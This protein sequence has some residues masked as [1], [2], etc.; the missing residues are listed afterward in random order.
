MNAPDERSVLT[1]EK[2]CLGGRCK[3]NEKE[4]R[5]DGNKRMIMKKK[6][7]E[8]WCRIDTLAVAQLIDKSHLKVQPA[9]TRYSLGLLL[10][11][12][13]HRM[14]ES[15]DKTNFHLPYTIGCRINAEERIADKHTI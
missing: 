13:S 2:K 9:A 8:K 4:T 1:K 11:K 14:C 5:R 12:K 6:L 15:V 10:F 3:A 7:K